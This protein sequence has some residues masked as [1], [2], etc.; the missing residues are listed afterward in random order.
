MLSACS[1]CIT[2]QQTN[3]SGFYTFRILSS[4]GQ[5]A[6]D[7]SSAAAEWTQAFRNANSNVS[8]SI[9]TDGDHAVYIDDTICPDWADAGG[10]VIRICSNL[11]AQSNDYIQRTVRHEIGHYAGFTNGACPKADSVMTAIQPSDMADHTAAIH[12]GCGDTASVLNYYHQQQ[13]DPCQFGCPPGY[14]TNC[15]GDQQP[16]GCGCCIN[17]SPILIDLEGS[18]I[19]FS[20]AEHGVLFL[21]NDR[22]S[23]LRVAW[24][25]RPT[26]AFLFLD[27]N[28]DGIVNSGA[29]LFGNTTR[30]KDGSIAENGFQA[31]AE[32]DDNHDG[33]IEV[34]DWAYGQ[35]KLWADSNRDG[36]SQASEILSVMT[37]GLVSIRVT[38]HESSRVDRWGNRY[39]FR[40]KAVFNVEPFERVAFDVF[41][42]AVRPDGSAVC[43]SRAVRSGIAH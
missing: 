41:P 42:V 29:E 7:F 40:S 34:H 8:F 39:A 24:P 33:L 31:L 32:L 23:V 25:L 14:T 37:A 15:V 38:P 1:S 35:L 17:Y 30:L 26:N 5:L 2:G 6:G 10:G 3:A 22:R 20:D 18:G 11:L 19:R 43:A 16:D 9:R 28:E 27:R 12:V 13:Y 4:V 21:I 36:V